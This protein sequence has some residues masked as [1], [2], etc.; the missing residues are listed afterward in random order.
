[1]NLEG[2]MKRKL[3]ALTFAAA[4]AIAG[5]A[6]PAS[7]AFAAISCQ[8][9]GGNAPQGNCNGAALSH[10]NPAGHAPPGQNP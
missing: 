5:A 8:N 7:G 9:P 1:M 3:I 6:A 2:P 4:V 10:V